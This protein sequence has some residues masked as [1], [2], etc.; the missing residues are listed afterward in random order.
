MDRMTRLESRLLEVSLTPTPAFA[1]AEVTMV[2]EAARR[3]AR[4]HELDY[5]KREYERLER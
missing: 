5:W 1:D 2:R 4:Q 3:A